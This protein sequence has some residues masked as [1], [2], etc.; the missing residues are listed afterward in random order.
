MKMFNDLAK[1]ISDHHAAGAKPAAPSMGAPEASSEPKAHANAGAIEAMH[2]DLAD[3][4]CPDC[5]SS[6]KAA[7]AKHG[8]HSGAAAAPGLASHPAVAGE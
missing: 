7:M 5:H 1:K 8:M 6:V 2:S 3:K 4:I